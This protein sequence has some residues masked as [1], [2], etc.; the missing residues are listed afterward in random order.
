MNFE[1]DGVL[2]NVA[3]RVVGLET[4]VDEVIKEVDQSL[5]EIDQERST[6]DQT[7]KEQI[8]DLKKRLEALE[9]VVSKERLTIG[10][11]KH[12]VTIGAYENMSGIWLENGNGPMVA[13]YNDRSAAVIGIYAEEKKEAVNIC[14]TSEGVQLYDNKT[15]N[16]QHLTIHQLVEVA[17]KLNEDK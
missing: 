9:S 14:L 12:K 7:H 10:K 8:A 2:P 1:A 15:K 5:T 6:N 3:K 16:V 13:I 17:R 11:G 4:K